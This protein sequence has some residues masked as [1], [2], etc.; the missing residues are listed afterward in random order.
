MNKFAEI[1]ES[2]EEFLQCLEKL[3]SP[4]SETERNDAILYYSEYFDDA[5]IENEKV[6]LAQLGSPK[7]VANKIIS[8]GGYIVEVK[9]NTNENENNETKENIGNKNYSTYEQKQ[10]PF[11]KNPTTLLLI[12][13]IAIFTFPIWISVLGI[14]IGLLGAV[15][16][17]FMGLVG[18]V[19]GLIV[20]GL[21]TCVVG[22][23]TI[24]SSLFD[25]LLTLGVGLI[26]FGIGL[27]MVPLI[28][29]IC[30]T[31][32]P[33]IVRFTIDVIKLPFRRKVKTH[34]SVL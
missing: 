13:I 28:V 16:G 31:I 27:L 15:F 12:I 20:G 19:I 30:T 21:A 10:T 34:E 32:I 6:I 18:V 25:G 11:Y 26:L 22:A 23:V 9:E 2:K 7:S 3:L 4:L 14:I 17:I 8:E 24:A 5:G 29:K 1:P 33:A